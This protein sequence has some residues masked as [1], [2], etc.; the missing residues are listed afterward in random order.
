MDASTTQDAP[1]EGVGSP[2]RGAGD[3]SSGGDRLA[4]SLL[5]GATVLA[6]LWSWLRVEG[7]LLYLL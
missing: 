5:L 1:R 4:W 7:A 2:A 6:G 3:G